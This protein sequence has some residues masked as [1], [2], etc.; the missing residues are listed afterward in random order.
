M[1]QNP[2]DQFDAPQGRGI[3]VKP[4]EAPDPRIPQTIRKTEQDIQDTV[5]ERARKNRN[6]ALDRQQKTFS[7]QSDLR[8]EF[9]GRLETKKWRTVRPI[10]ETAK[11]TPPTPA[12]DLNLVFAFAKIVDPESVVREG[13]A[14]AVQNTDTLAGQ[15][16]ARLQKELGE[17]GIFSDAS[18]Q[19]LRAEMQRRMVALT[20]DY[21]ATRQQYAR[22]ASGAGFPVN[23]ILGE[24]PDYKS[25]TA[26][27][28]NVDRKIASGGT[29]ST[30]GD[31]AAQRVLQ[32][33]AQ[34]GAGFDQLQAAARELNYNLPSD[35]KTFME[36]NPGQVPTIGTPESGVTSFLNDLAASD[37]GAV[38]LGV[39]NIGGLADEVAAAGM[40][41]TNDGLRGFVDGSFG[42]NLDEANRRKQDIR[43]A[44]PGAFMAGEVVGN[45]AAPFAA[46]KMAGAAGSRLL[47]AA[48]S[49]PIL[50]SV[51]GGG[52]YGVGEENDSRLTGG[53]MNALAGGAGGAVGK[54]A[55]APLAQAVLDS[56]PVRNTVN[57]IGNRFGRQEVIPE[58]VDAGQRMI[59]NA[60]MQDPVGNIRNFLTDAER[61]GLPAALADASPQLRSL[62]GAATRRSP[63][64]R[65]IAEDR[66]LPRALGQADR[67]QEQIARNLAAPVDPA[68]LTRQIEQNASN[69]ARPFYDDAFARPAPVNDD[70]ANIL[71]NPTMQ[72]AYNRA[73]RIAENE[74]IDPRTIGFDLND[75]GEVMLVQNPSWRTIDLIKRGL[76]SQLYKDGMKLPTKGDPLL[77][78]IDTLRG[79]YMEI[80]DKLPGADNYKK[81]RAVYQE[82]IA[83]RTALQLG[84]QAP[85][86]QVLP[87]TVQQ[88]FGGLAPNQVT[89]FQQGY[90][91][92]LSDTVD[93]TRFSSNPYETIYGSPAA[94]AKV[95]TVFPQGARDFDR[96]YRI[97]QQMGRTGTETIGGSP[98]AI[99]QRIDEGFDVG[100]GAALG[101]DAA[102]AAMTGGAPV[103]TLARA[104]TQ[105]ISDRAR[106]GLGVERANKIGP[107]LLDTNPSAAL[108]ALDELDYAIKNRLPYEQSVRRLGGVFGSGLGV[109]GVNL[110]RN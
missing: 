29:K 52:A 1:A 104:V 81:A 90:A 78:S 98:T 89:P 55:V 74:G 65:Q 102:T 85:R 11:S 30:E 56:A 76:D 109:G 14:A 19:S 63:D 86:T 15:T 4:P 32:A 83:P 57:N 105:G 72:E 70:L 75:Q 54:F 53:A 6:D 68:A 3:L 39:T 23:D 103:A 62:A 77:Q 40:T 43:D 27:L 58:N 71:N 49:R 96:A 26:P 82:N 101:L 87:R 92:S 67:A 50:A 17:G 60:V 48:A 45:I 21:Q 88:Q 12:G 25:I 106:I 34:S 110:Y 93:R 22:I 8:K 24:E 38:A 59:G 33:L 16:V 18:R 9:E 35:L 99:R 51:I 108:A 2:F 46:A 64:V 41:I 13:E 5:E 37:A 31:I 91:T 100:S 107:T 7:N 61:L 69:Q 84:Q 79:R 97:E 95:G 47:G 80:V 42:R 44:N 20:Q 66:L 28:P 73:A 94:Q 10:Y 36:Q